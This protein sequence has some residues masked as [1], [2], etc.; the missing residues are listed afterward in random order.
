VDAEPNQASVDQLNDISQDSSVSKGVRVVR[1]ILDQYNDMLIDFEAFL[2]LHAGQLENQ[3]QLFIGDDPERTAS[4]TAT[5][6]MPIVSTLRQR[7]DGL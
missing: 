3:V 4:E 6:A 7:I 1:V 2:S 5:S